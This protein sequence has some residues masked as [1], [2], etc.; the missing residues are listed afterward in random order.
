MNIFRMWGGSG[1]QKDRFYELCDECGI[2]VWQ[3]FPLVCNNYVNDPHYLEILEQEA[4]CIVKSLR[5]HPCVVLWCGGNELF[6]GWS[7]MTDQHHA[8]RLLNKIC[9]DHDRNTPFLATSPLAGMAHGCYLFSY[10]G[11][12]VYR[13]FNEAH[14]TAYTEFGVPS[15][16]PTYPCIS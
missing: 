12:E 5:K 16:A 3:E 15:V 10:E 2:M 6:N 8:L 7:K 1:I 13:M 14:Y 9:Y 11:K 4:T